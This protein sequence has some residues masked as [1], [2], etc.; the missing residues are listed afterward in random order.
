MWWTALV[1][2]VAALENLQFTE[3]TFQS[4]GETKFLIKVTGDGLTCGTADEDPILKAQYNLGSIFIPGVSPL[5]YQ[6]ENG[7]Q[8]FQYAAPG[9][10]NQNELPEW[11]QNRDPEK[12]LYRLINEDDS[13]LLS[14][15]FIPEVSPPDLGVH[16]PRQFATP[17]N[18]QP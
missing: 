18:P 13:P 5:A 14:G 7:S 16:N 6:K 3:T 2:C 10:S 9:G 1:G 11:W 8:T 17:A 15:M 4:D 12:N